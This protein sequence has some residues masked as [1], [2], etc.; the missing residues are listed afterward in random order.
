MNANYAYVAQLVLSKFIK[1]LEVKLSSI[2][3][4]NKTTAENW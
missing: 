2:S 4:W 3:K 1:T